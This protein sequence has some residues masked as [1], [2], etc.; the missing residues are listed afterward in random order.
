MNVSAMRNSME[1]SHPIP[2]ALDAARDSGGHHSPTP[3][4]Q[5]HLITGHGYIGQK[6]FLSPCA[7]DFR[8]DSIASPPQRVHRAAKC[9][10]SFVSACIAP[11]RLRRQSAP[12]ALPL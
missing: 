7:A 2:A 3:Q 1:L 10:E 4:T 5:Y 9:I 12:S 6:T 11:L 8:R